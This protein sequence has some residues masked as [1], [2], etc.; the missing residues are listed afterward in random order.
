[1]GFVG[2]W[3]DAMLAK[4]LRYLWQTPAKL[5]GDYV[6]PGATVF[7]VGCG[8]GYYSLGLAKLVGASGRVI[9]VDTQPEMIDA[10]RKQAIQKG[11]SRRIDARVC[12][13]TDLSVEDLVGQV[14]FALAVYVVHHAASSAGLMRSVYEALKPGGVLL[15][16]EPKHHASRAECEVTEAAARSTGFVVAG[17]PKLRR[18]WA[19]K[20]VKS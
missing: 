14:D 5:L 18:D 1:M 15:V 6:R 12:D 17:H 11:W 13:D 8:S 7:D 9:A 10:L 19:V 20:L 3:I 2:R 4:P 16:V